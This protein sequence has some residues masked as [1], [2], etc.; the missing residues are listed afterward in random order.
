[1]PAM[2]IT[3]R[4]V[5]KADAA[6]LLTIYNDAVVHTTSVWTD[7]PR[8]LEAQNQWLEDKRMSGKPVLVAEE[9]G[10]VIGFSSYGPFRAWPGYRHTVENMIYVAPDHR[11]KGV[12][13]LLLGPLIERARAQQLHAII[14]GIEATNAVSLKLHAKHG[15]TQVGQLK[16]VGTKFGRWLD[17]V[18]LQRML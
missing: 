2:P 15:F 12:G 14:A 9:Q 8:T 1:M 11:G 18:F 10:A 7:E 3:I 4:D 17:L 13:S 16:E 5:K 6:A